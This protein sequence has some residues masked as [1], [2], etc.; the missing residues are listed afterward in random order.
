MKKLLLPVLAC[1]IYISVFAQTDSE[2]CCSIIKKNSKNN[3]V[4]ARDNTT[5]RL[6]QFKAD[7]LDINAVKA[8]D[9]V[10]IAQNKIT[11]ING[12]TRTYVAVKPDYVEPCCPIVSIQPD[13]AEPCCAIVTL[14]NNA[15]GALSSFKAPKYISNKSGRP[16]LCGAPK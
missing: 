15:T 4:I 2:P 3:T 16:G 11:A 13:P 8:G 9:P 1:G 5:G 7:A 10:T 6:Y 12:A 14:K